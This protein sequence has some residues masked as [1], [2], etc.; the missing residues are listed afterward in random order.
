MQ[1]SQVN[2]ENFF[3]WFD[4]YDLRVVIKLYLYNSESVKVNCPQEELGYNT[5]D[6]GRK[7]HDM[8]FLIMITMHQ[9]SFFRIELWILEGTE[10]YK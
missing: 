1:K 10:L 7:T 9:W 5:Q 6:A 4:R 2:A 3:T 8:W